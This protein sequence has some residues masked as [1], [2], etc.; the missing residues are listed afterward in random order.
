MQQRPPLRSTST[1]EHP[2]NL[3]AWKKRQDDLIR[4]VN[5]WRRAHGLTPEEAAS[6]L[7]DLAQLPGYLIENLK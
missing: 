6:D 1:P 2:N 5:H 4:A 3:E 7:N